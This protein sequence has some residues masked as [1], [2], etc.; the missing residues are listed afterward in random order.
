MQ[1]LRAP[2]TV[3]LSALTALLGVVLIVET[4][5]VGGALGFLLGALLL[6]AGGL[7]LALVLRRR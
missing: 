2:A 1:R 7:R 4:A 6:A 5:V 3:V